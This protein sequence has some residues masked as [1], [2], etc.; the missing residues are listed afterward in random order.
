ME[1][2]TKQPPCTAREQNF[3]SAVVYLHGAAAGTAGFFARLNRLL[4]ARFSQYELIAVDD[5][6]SPAVLEELRCWGRELERP[7]TIVHMSL[8]QGIERAM[9][10]GLDCAIGDYIYEFD[11]PEDDWPEELL[12]RAYDTALAGS[13]IVS[14]C[15][16]H[17]RFSSRLFYRIFNH[18]SGSA[19]QLRTDVF[20][21]VSRR[22]VNRVYAVSERLSYRKA[23]YAASG[24]KMT[25][26]LFEGG[27]P[28][29]GEGR[30]GLA[31]D[32]LALYTNAGYRFSVGV[33]G[34][35]LCAALAELIYTVVIYVTGR[36]IEGWTT[37]MFVLT[38]GL[39]G[40]FAVLAIVLKY[41]S[42]ILAMTFTR[43]TNLVEGIEKIQK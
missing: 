15:P 41:L 34:A 33:T 30:F 21:L 2:E 16:E 22:A 23:A 28:H 11:A 10:A 9:N 14:V 1:D 19:Y 40:L 8:Y 18:S 20:R 24:L 12:G 31:V 25:A 13:D 3:I 35:M 29:H 27:P 32:S 26:L 6:C 5:R 39:F 17:Q 42:L 36:P 4:E 37:M 43:P 7:L 38:F